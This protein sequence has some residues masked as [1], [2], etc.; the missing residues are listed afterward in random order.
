MAAFTPTASARANIAGDGSSV[1]SL[2]LLLQMHLIE[3]RRVL[4]QLIAL[5]PSS[6]GDATNYSALVATLAKI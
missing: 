3:A 4:A 1:D 2:N 5:H 6:G